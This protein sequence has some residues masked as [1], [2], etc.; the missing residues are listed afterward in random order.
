MVIR[1]MSELFLNI[2]DFSVRGVKK[3]QKNPENPGIQTTC[4][5]LLRHQRQ[6]WTFYYYQFQI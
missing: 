2:L 4:N 5:C 3:C 6:S 1:E